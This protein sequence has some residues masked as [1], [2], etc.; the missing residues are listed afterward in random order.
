MTAP[1]W[2]LFRIGL[3]VLPSS[4]L[5]AAVPLFLSCIAGSRGRE[6]ILWRDGWMVPLLAASVLMLIGAC[7]A[8]TGGLA[9]AGL[10]NWIPFFWAFWAFRPFVIS[11]ERRQRSARWLLAGTVPVLVTGFGQML[12]GWAGPWY[13]LRLSLGWAGLGPGRLGRNLEDGVGL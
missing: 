5:L 13:C 4:A 9:W 6:P 1:G 11:A 7:L 2:L 3:F 8:D 10:A 12:L